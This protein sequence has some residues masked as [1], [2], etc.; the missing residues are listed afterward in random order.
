MNDYY[1]N[2][3]RPTAQDGSPY[4]FVLNELSHELEG[5]TV[6]VSGRMINDSTET[7]EDVLAVISIEETTGRFPATLEI[8]VDPSPLEPGESGIFSMSVTLRQAPIRYK[9]QFKLE[10]GPF[11]L[12]RDERGLGFEMVVPDDEPL[13]LPE[14]N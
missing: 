8:P 7:L 13:A 14:L 4:A 10:H 9:V 1:L 5:R 2:V 6:T 11:V 3:V 12:H